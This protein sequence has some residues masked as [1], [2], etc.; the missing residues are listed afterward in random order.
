VDEGDLFFVLCLVLGV[1]PI[2]EPW[3]CSSVE[4]TAFSTDKPTC[5]QICNNQVICV[6]WIKESM[7]THRVKKKIK[8]K[9]TIIIWVYILEPGSI[10]VPLATC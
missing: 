10:D 7:P 8:K 9:K 1:G 4:A 3:C 5:L 6:H 2:E